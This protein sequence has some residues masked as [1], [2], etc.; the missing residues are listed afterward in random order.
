MP[1]SGMFHSVALVRTDVSK[2][3]IVLFR[4]VFRLLLT[5]NVPNTDS[6]KPDDRSDISPKHLFLRETHGITSLKTAFFIVTSMK[7]LI[8][9]R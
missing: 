3:I 4:G 2:E 6:F 1:S 7:Q 9:N 8:L 5:A